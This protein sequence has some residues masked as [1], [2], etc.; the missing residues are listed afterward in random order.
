MIGRTLARRLSGFEVKLI[1]TNPV[2]PT[3]QEAARLKAG[4]REPDDLFREADIVTLHAPFDASAQHMICE[5]TINLMK[6]DAILISCARGEAPL[7]VVPEL[8]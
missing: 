7:W 1:Y 6:R 2:R 8:R 4:Y 5:R 3:P